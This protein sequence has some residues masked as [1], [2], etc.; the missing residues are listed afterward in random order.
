MREALLDFENTVKLQ[1]EVD[2]R[3]EFGVPT[4]ADLQRVLNI[5]DE[6]Y[7]HWEELCEQEKKKTDVEEVY[8]RRFSAA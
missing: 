1:S 7:D 3:L 8:L 5:M 2:E 4:K 6:V